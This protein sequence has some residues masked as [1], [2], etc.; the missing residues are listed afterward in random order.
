MQKVKA[1]SKN[2]QRPKV[3]KELEGFDIRINPFGEIVSNIGID[4]INAFLNDNIDDKKLTERK[5]DEET[6]EGEK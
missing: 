3:H 1:V 5:D 2:K 6:R 4:K